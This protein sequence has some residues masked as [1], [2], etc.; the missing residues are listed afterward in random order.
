MINQKIPTL[1]L[2]RS[3]VENFPGYHLSRNLQHPIDGAK[4]MFL[5]DIKKYLVF[6]ITKE[7]KEAKETTEIKNNFLTD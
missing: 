4:L 7:A 5:N 3:G 6:F 2:P 1:E